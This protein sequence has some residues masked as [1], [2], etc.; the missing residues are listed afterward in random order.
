MLEKKDLDDLVLNGVTGGTNFRAGQ[1]L[2]VCNVQGNYLPI[3]SCPVYSKENEIYNGIGLVNGDIVRFEGEVVKG[4]NEFRQGTNYVR[5]FIL[6][7]NCYGYV[8]SKFL[9]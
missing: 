6:K 3:L 4:L 1:C 2:V 9:E 5:A 7:Y 8:D